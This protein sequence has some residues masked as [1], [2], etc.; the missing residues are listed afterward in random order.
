MSLVSEHLEV[1]F[2]NLVI[3]KEIVT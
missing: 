2:G 3:L 1:G